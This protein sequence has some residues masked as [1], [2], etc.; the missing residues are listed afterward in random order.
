MNDT[1]AK[2]LKVGDA[3]RWTCPDDPEETG[4]IVEVGYNAVK[5]AWDDGCYGIM[6]FAECEYVE[7][8]RQ[9]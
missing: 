4:K 8:V 9:P 7:R 2:R 5:I 1:Q 3:V 6:R